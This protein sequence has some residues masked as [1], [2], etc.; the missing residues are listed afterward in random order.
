M[1]KNVH[2]LKSH[3][4]IRQLSLKSQPRGHYVLP[5][6]TRCI[7]FKK[8]AP[9]AGGKHKMASWGGSWGALGASWAVLGPSGSDFKTTSKKRQFF[10]CNLDPQMSNPPRRWGACWE[11]K[12][13]QDGTQNGSKMKTIFN[14]EKVAL[15]EPLGT[16]LGRS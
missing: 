16:V 5:A 3:R 9:H 2:F 12:T 13:T 14:I 6:R 8:Y 11:P 10:G 7:F 15:Q 4:F 1:A